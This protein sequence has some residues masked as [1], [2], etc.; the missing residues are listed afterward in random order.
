M[1]NQPKP[2][3]PDRELVG[4]LTLRKIPAKPA[5]VA[6]P[7]VTPPVIPTRTNPPVTVA[8]LGEKPKPNLAEIQRAVDIVKRPGVVYEMRA[9]KTHKRTIAGYYND[10][11]VFAQ[12][13]HDLSEIETVPNVYWTLQQIDPSL[14]ARSANEARGFTD[15]TTSDGSV[16]RYLWLPFDFDPCRVAGVS[17]TDVEKERAKELATV[18]RAFLLE[19]K[20]SSVLADSGNGYHLLVRVDLPVNRESTMLVSSILSAAQTKYGTCKCAG[21]E[22][23]CGL[24]KIDTTLSNPSR[25]LKVYGTVAR[26]GSHT[27]ERPWR[28]S[29]IIDAPECAIVSEESLRALLKDL[30]GEVP[31]TTAV[32]SDGAW[33]GW[34]PEQM[35]TVLADKELAHG[36]RIPY[37]NGFK[38]QLAECPFNPEHKS[39]DSFMALERSGLRYFHCSHD[40]CADNCKG[41]EGWAKFKEQVGGFD[42]PAS[43][44]V[45]STT[46]PA[47]PVQWGEPKTFEPLLSPVP[48]CKLD[49]LPESFRGYAQ[50]VAERMS[51]PLDYVVICMMC[52]FAAVVGRRAFVY[53]KANDNSW[54]EALNLLGAVVAPSGSKKSP[55]WRHFVS[56]ILQIEADWREAHAQQMI[57]HS[58][59]MAIYA[60]IK[61]NA[62]KDKTVPPDPPLP[63]EPRRRIVF[64][65]ATPEKMHAM[66]ETNPEGLYS[67]QDEIGGWLAMM[68]KK[69]REAERRMFLAAANG[70]EWFTLDR[71]ERGEVGAWMCSSYFGGMQPFVCQALVNDPR[72]VGDGTTARFGLLSYPDNVTFTPRIDRKEDED[73][74]TR[75]SEVLRIFAPLRVRAISLKFAQDAQPIFNEWQN[76]HDERV[77]SLP[78]NVTRSHL[79]KYSGL[80]PRLAALYQLADLAA[81]M[82]DS[83]GIVAD[84]SGMVLI[85]AAHL[86]RAIAFVTEYL[87]PHMNRV[88]G[89]IK[90][91]WQLGE[92]ALAEHIKAG[93]LPEPFTARE[94]GRKHWSHLRDAEA[95]SFAIETFL[96]YGWL[97]QIPTPPKAREGRPASPRFEVNPAAVDRPRPSAGKNVVEAL[98]YSG[99]AL[100]APGRIQARAVV[101]AAHA[102]KAPTQKTV[103]AI[104]CE[105]KV[106]GWPK[107]ART[108]KRAVSGTR[109]NP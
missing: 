4:G 21:D 31:M 70:D 69:G 6:Q 53:P 33:E 63:P 92:A 101:H 27:A 100:K 35:E 34:T 59:Q 105:H 61:K 79:S 73:A 74:K 11:T 18:F 103:R 13:A 37:K 78:D 97:R 5:P 109:R 36:P 9:V 1:K 72:N 49:Y 45:A 65:D 40:S 28:L 24:I 57:D 16:Q 56:P 8:A 43:T 25:I 67:F 87:E 17:S 52:S 102:W 76:T 106:G 84:L 20:V 66:M 99:R 83:E 58:K 54:K 95:V 46:T 81:V 47:E 75:Y 77:L 62:K 86:S 80:V 91:A 51:L 10:A 104:F 30:G 23:A 29:R 64:N 98:M 44:P 85:D 89:C 60:Q 96:E 41:K 94:I 3:D 2:M 39:P 71:I 7:A 68:D 14:L 48:P 38:W 90:S 12:D 93:D 55:A 26:K 42:L 19:R 107:R 82:A 88:Y 15:I 32:A 108:L 50:D 22:A